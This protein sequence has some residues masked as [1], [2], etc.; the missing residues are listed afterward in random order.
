M[1][2]APPVSIRATRTTRPS[3]CAAQ[4]HGPHH[5]VA[6]EQ[7]ALEAGADRPGR[8][9]LLAR[10]PALRAGACLLARCIWPERSICRPE[11]R[12]RIGSPG[13]AASSHPAAVSSVRPITPRSI[14]SVR[15]APVGEIRAPAQREPGRLRADV[16][17]RRSAGRRRARSAPSRSPASPARLVQPSG[18][19]SSAARR[20]IGARPARRPRPN[21]PGCRSRRDRPHPAPPPP[22]RARRPRAAPRSPCP[23]PRPWS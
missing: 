23:T 12:R 8:P 13:R 19:V 7:H 17:D 3:L 9:G 5:V 4:R 22:C 15:G 18:P 11:M 2:A 14:T 6:G 20:E 10:R 21:A 16:L 1:R